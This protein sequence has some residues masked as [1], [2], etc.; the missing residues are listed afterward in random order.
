[1]SP[2]WDSALD[3]PSPREA[4]LL[5]EVLEA[6]GAHLEA[7]PLPGEEPAPDVAELIS[8]ALAEL[9]RVAPDWRR[10]GG[11]AP[12][13]G[14]GITGALLRRAR[15]LH[16]QDERAGSPTLDQRF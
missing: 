12:V 13:L 11:I 16:P 8:A 9:Q 2:R 1:M 10:E 14:A 3:R 4:A 6:L 5:A 7:E 15:S